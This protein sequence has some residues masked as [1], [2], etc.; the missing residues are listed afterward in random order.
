MANEKKYDSGRVIIPVAHPDGHVDRIA[1][2][3]DHSNL[4]IAAL[5]NPHDAISPETRTDFHN[6]LLDAGYAHP[7]IEARIK[8]PT[9]AGALENT[10]EF[11]QVAQKMFDSVGLGAL[12]EEARAVVPKTGNI[13]ILST[14]LGTHNNIP[15]S[16]V[17]FASIHTHP[18]AKD[19]KPSDADIAAAR[20]SNKPA[21]IVSQRGLYMVRPSDGKVLQVFEGQDPQHWKKK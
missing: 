9:E 6:A 4:E 18:N 14:S 13:N 11:R 20:Q 19:P 17:S 2:P 5:D 1:V 15:L 3:T 12:N 21:F 10:P 7:A 8:Q 16:P